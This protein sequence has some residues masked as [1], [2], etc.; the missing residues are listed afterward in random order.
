MPRT[1]ETENLF[2]AVY[3][4]VQQIPHGSVTSYGHIARLIGRL[5][6]CLK[7]LPASAAGGAVRFDAANVP[8]QRVINARGSISPRC[9]YRRRR[10]VWGWQCELMP[11]ASRGFQGL[12]AVAQLEKLEA[13]GVLVTRG[14]VG[15]LCV[16]LAAYGW[17]PDALPG[18][19][20]EDET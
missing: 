10:G 4:A 13:E 9:V 17:F 5:G 7:Q 20:G 1:E 2:T 3:R 8:W 14:P 19:Q 6:V 16:D 11:G 12:G 15:E 18:Q